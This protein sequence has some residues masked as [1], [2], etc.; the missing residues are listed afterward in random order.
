MSGVQI[1]NEL[2]ADMKVA[3]TYRTGQTVANELAKDPSDNTRNWR[4][5]NKN[6]M[7]RTC[8]IAGA[9]DVA[10][11]DCLERGKQLRKGNPESMAFKVDG[12]RHAW[13]PHDPD[14]FTR[15][16]TAW[17]E[18]E[19]LTEEFIALRQAQAIGHSNIRARSCV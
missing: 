18:Q 13:E 12:K 16:I 3:S 10:E 8:V 7:T 9:V 1:G 19:D 4:G 2:L 5:L 11:K 15:S 14:L 17:V 6:V